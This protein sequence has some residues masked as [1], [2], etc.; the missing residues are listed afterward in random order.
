VT[1]NVKFARHVNRALTLFQET[2]ELQRVDL[3]ALQEMDEAGVDRVARSLDMNYVYYPAV[4]HRSHGK[5]FG[6]ALLSPWPIQDDRKILLPHPGGKTR[7]QRIAVRGTIKVG[8]RKLRGYSIHLGTALEIGPRQRRKQVEAILADSETFDGPVI[9]VGDM[10]A[11]GIGSFLERKGFY[12]ATRSVRRT[13]SLFSWDHIFMR[14]F[15]TGQISKVGIVRDNRKAS[16]HKPVW[17]VLRLDRS[18]PPSTPPTKRRLVQRVFSKPRR[19]R[20]EKGFS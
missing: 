19:R 18:Q 10:N 5:N 1:F 17:M 12:W 16:D 4:V 11:R 15:D 8:Q 13:I 3:L 14:G 6:N 2:P 9:L 20:I 7:D